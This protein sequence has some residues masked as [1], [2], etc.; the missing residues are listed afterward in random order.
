M[1][2]INKVSKSF[3]AE[4]ILQDI[5][6][7][8]NPGD[9]IG[10]IGQNGSGKSTLLKIISGELSPDSGSVAVSAGTTIG[11]LPQ[12]QPREE[13][14][15]VRELILQGI[16]EWA[17]ARREMDRLADR[18]ARP[19]EK[20]LETL[21]ARYS[22]AQN[23][24]EML[25]GYGLE[26]QVQKIA[27]GLGLPS[28]S[29]D[30]P[31]DTMSGGQ[32]TRV[33]L[34]RLLIASPDLLL[35]DE[36]TNHLDIAALEWL[37]TT[38][39]TFP[40]GI[41]I[42][43]HDRVFLDRTIN[44]VIVLDL[45]T[46]TSREYTGTYS[47]YA[48]THAREIDRV[49]ESWRDQQVEIKRM[50]ADIHRT[51]MHAKSVE[52]TTTS[53]QPTV[54]RL[55]KKVARKAKSREKKLERYMDSDERVE[56]PT[57][58]WQMNLSFDESLRSGQRVLTVAG[59]A[60]TYPGTGEVLKSVELELAYGDRVVLAGENGSGK[61]TLLK[62]IVGE[63]A[64]DTGMLSLGS[65]VRIGYMPQEQEALPMEWT[66]LQLIQA[67]RPMS[68]TDARNFLHYFLFE[69]DGAL[70]PIAR[71]SYGERS[72]LLL[73]KLVVEGANFLV[74]DEPLNHLDIP[75]RERFEAALAAFPGTVLAA[76]HD[77]AFIRNYAGRVINI[78]AGCLHETNPA[79]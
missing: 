10:I 16:A 21:L 44:K 54:R 45:E 17:S 56:K 24:F 9:R 27:A 34:A 2:Q 14:R 55:A 60:F 63:L 37:E 3:G 23:R 38:I 72:R 13:N 40:G 43:S 58:G 52:L 20:D 64:P 29:L 48:E 12:G 61:S 42:V 59:L 33:G 46:H 32:R 78:E 36:P 70:L 11:Y 1:L 15:T 79:H 73:A 53:G 76:V 49:R 75:S 25:G 5:R 71:L 7:V 51:K 41:L 28:E 62:I 8:V 4:T 18:I 67:A 66:P 19:E 39:S 35:L 77:R 26:H 65:S 6:F 50:E 74:L 30:R 69:G 68:E 22:D 31:I 47:D 57:A